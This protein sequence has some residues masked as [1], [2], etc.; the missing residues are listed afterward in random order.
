MAK[1]LKKGDRVQWNSHGAKA[2]GTVKRKITSDSEAAGRKVRA[3][4]ENPQYLVESEKSG[5]TAVHKPDA[6]K[7][8]SKKK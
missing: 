2:L 7:K 1:D 5:G 6:L 3:S 4:N 8:K